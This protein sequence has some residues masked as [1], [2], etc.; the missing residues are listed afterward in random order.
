M[1]I[2]TH[3][4]TYVYAATMTFATLSILQLFHS[5]NVR[6]EIHSVLGKEFFA[7]RPLV[8][9]TLVS[10][11]LQVFVIQGDQWISSITNSD[12]VYFSSIFEV[13]PLEFID[14]VVILIVTSSLILFEEIFKFRKRRIEGI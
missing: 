5:Y 2:S 3:D 8:W 4:P 9:A 14:W 6:S 1:N 13:T 10:A 11:L 7:N 12:F